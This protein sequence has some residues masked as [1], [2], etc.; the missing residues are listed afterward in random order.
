MD[1]CSFLRITVATGI[2]ALAWL[3]C[4]SATVCISGRIETVAGT[5]TLT[6]AAVATSISAAVA[7]TL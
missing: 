2:R 5:V 7:K 6:A 1:Y 3:A 4:V